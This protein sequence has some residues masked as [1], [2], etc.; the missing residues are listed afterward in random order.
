MRSLFFEKKSNSVM[1]M[2]E[3]K[4]VVTTGELQNLSVLVCMSFLVG[5]V[6][7]CSEASHH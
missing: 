2:F 3:K 4:A 6:L 7:C 1:I 5:L